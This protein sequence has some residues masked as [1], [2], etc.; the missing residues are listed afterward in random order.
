MNCDH[1]DQ[2]LN[3]LLDEHE[4]V[5][6]DRQ[7]RNHAENCRDCS[8]RLRIWLCVDEALSGSVSLSGNEASPETAA[9]TQPATAA[10]ASRRLVVQPT[11]AIPAVFTTAC[12]VLLALGVFSQLRVADH[13]VVAARVQSEQVEQ[14]EPSSSNIE[15]NAFSL[16]RT[17]AESKNT[18]LSNQIW[19]VMQDP[20]WTLESLPAVDS[21][22]QSVAPIGRSMQQAAAILMNH[23]ERIDSSAD[24]LIKEIPALEKTSI[25]GRSYPQSIS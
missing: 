19:T 4:D 15:P 16:S 7:L 23:S 9:T 6:E 25:Y 18:L 12:A 20:Q 21:V 2:R 1:F 3:D 5:S 8:D 13:S 22:R 24:P 11:F 17:P 14:P 10:T